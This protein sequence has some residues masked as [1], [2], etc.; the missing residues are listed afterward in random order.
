MDDRTPAPEEKLTETR[1]VLQSMSRQRFGSIPEQLVTDHLLRMT[2]DADFPVRKAALEALLRR[3]G[4]ARRDELRIA[5][6]PAEGRS[7]LGEYTTRGTGPAQPAAEAERSSAFALF[8]HI[9]QSFL[10]KCPQSGPLAPRSGFCFLEKGVGN[11]YSSLHMGNHIMIYG[12]MQGISK[13]H[14][15]EFFCDRRTSQ[16]GEGLEE[17][18]TEEDLVDQEPRF[19]SLRP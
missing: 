2:E 13:K 17:R 18:G 14:L 3:Q 7:V 4:F 12:F 19:A 10:H 11:L 1:L 9:P 8:E 6:R 5:S 16:H 15:P